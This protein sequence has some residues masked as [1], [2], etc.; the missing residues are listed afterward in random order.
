MLL[1]AD[2]V[3]KSLAIECQRLGG[4]DDA[5]LMGSSQQAVAMALQLLRHREVGQTAAVR[6]Q[7]ARLLTAL[8]D[9]APLLPQQNAVD[10]AN[11]LDQTRT[12]L[13]SPSDLP[14]LEALWLELARWAEHA[15]AGLG[16]A[17]IP[18]EH[19][20]RIA[21]TLARWEVAEL[22]GALRSESV[23]SIA[24]TGLDAERMTAYLRERFDDASLIV[25]SFRALMGG[26]GKQTY[27]FTVRGEKLD[28]DY[29]LRRDADRPFV[30]NDCHRIDIEFA[31]IRAAHD[32][33]FPAPDPLWVDT[34]HRLLPG[35]HFLVMK[36]SPGTPGGDV[37]SSASGRP[38]NLSDTLAQILARLHALPFMPELAQLNEST[39]HALAQMPLRDCVRLYLQNWRELFLRSPHLPSPAIAAQFSWL[40]D[41]LPALP[42]APAL[43]HGDIGFHNFLFEQGQL[44]AVLDWEFAHL[45][46]PA[47]DLAYVRNT[48]GGSLD[49]P[50][51]MAA[52]RAAGGVEISDARL[53]FFQVWGHLRNACAANLAAAAFATGAVDDLKMVL[54]PHAHMPMFI[55]A[56]RALIEQTPTQQESQHVE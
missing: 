32:R 36:R 44:T 5:H 51:F 35:G 52:Y 56:A 26:F 9:I 45:G 43:L 6:A 2:L 49:W 38:A 39:N 24:N 11:R 28:G 25:S 18:A 31:M 17:D 13:L 15:V 34:E 55:A 33:G 7:I 14:T 16:R 30:D 42:G 48:I 27:L 1:S 20:R 12:Q 3:L 19:W 47:E 8:E 4:A 29:V 50:A 23:G 10:I 46:D 22:G 53:H 40:L 41:H 37:F 54:L 21:D